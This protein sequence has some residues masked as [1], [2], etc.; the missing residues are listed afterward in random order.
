MKHESFCQFLIISVTAY[1]IG[2]DK[3]DLTVTVINVKPNN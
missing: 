1:A 3:Y 2:K